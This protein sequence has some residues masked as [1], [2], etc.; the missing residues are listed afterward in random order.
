VCVF[1]LGIV[2]AALVAVYFAD[3]KSHRWFTISGIG[4]VQPSEFAK[5]ALILFLAYFLARRSQVINQGRTLLQ[6]GLAVAMVAFLVVVGDLG[7]AI[8]PVITTVIVVVVAGLNGGTWFVS[9]RWVVALAAVAVVA[10]PF[11]WA[12]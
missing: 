1:G 7:T 6:A 4:S 12:A 8:V 3:P 10:K 2:L 9:W 11:A 5:P